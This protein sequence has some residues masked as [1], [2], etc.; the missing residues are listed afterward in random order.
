[1]ETN[2]DKDFNEMRFFFKEITAAYKDLLK[3][4]KDNENYI[5]KENSLLYKSYGNDELKTLLSRKKDILKQNSNILQTYKKDRFYLYLPLGLF[6]LFFI[7][8]FLILHIFY[9]LPE[10]INVILLLL[11]SA[12]AITQN[13]WYGIN[14]DKIKNKIIKTL[15]TSKGD[16]DEK[17]EKEIKRNEL[18][19]ILERI[20]TVNNKIENYNHIYMYDLDRN[21]TNISKSLSLVL[22]IIIGG[23]LGSIFVYLLEHF[24]SI[25]LPT[26]SNSLGLIL[27]SSIGGSIWNFKN[28]SS[29]LTDK[30]ESLA[31]GV[32]HQI[33]LL[34]KETPKE[35]ND[36]LW[37]EYSKLIS[38]LNSVEI[39]KINV[40]KFKKH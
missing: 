25:T 39:K 38:K 34:P 27:G 7:I 36:K 11:F 14:K 12:I 15:I 30:Y 24:S 22:L 18:I 32:L 29:V 13:V 23:V 17:N 3:T 19:E 4:Y 37:K 10:I 1:M 5:Y 20:N 21:K 16:L 8:L 2:T 40:F 31:S 35:V 6:V 26:Y 33:M 9:Q 28:S